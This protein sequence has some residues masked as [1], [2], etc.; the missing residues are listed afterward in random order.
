MASSP[1]RPPLFPT[2]PDAWRTDQ[3]VWFRSS[4]Y[5]ATYRGG[6]RSPCC[7]RCR[8][9]SQRRPQQPEKFLDLVQR[10]VGDIDDVLVSDPKLPCQEVRSGIPHVEAVNYRYN[11]R[12]YGKSGS[13]RANQIRR[14]VPKYK[15]ARW[16]GALIDKSAGLGDGFFGGDGVGFER[17]LKIARQSAKGRE[18]L[19]QRSEERRV[20]KE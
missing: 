11:V 3:S 5:L 10:R 15:Q 17:Y 18:C 13:Q 7:G 2:M 12:G 6:Y 9:R 14:L 1:E 20:G 16:I 19:G 4:A 8:G